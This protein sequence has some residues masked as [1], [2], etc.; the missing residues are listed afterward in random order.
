[1][2]NEG[3][4]L[5]NTSKI[6][7]KSIFSGANNLDQFWLD[8]WGIEGRNLLLIRDE[9][10]PMKIEIPLGGNLGGQVEDMCSLGQKKKRQSLPS[11]ALR[12]ISQVLHNG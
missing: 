12:P 2:K 10:L 6:L 4:K 8:A 11:S 7:R 1:M 5:L 3:L 9:N